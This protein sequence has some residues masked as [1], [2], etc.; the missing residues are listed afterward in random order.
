MA[1]APQEDVQIVGETLDDAQQLARCARAGSLLVTRSLVARLPESLRSQ[2]VYGV[3]A[4]GQREGAPSRLMTFARLREIA[5]PDAGL[6]R[7]LAALPVTEIVDVR[8]RSA[9]W[10]EQ[11]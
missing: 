6:P 10:K 11:E 5:P 7:R 1:P 2:V 4:A 9:D 3:P 8:T